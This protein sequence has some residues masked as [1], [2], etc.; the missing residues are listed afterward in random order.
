MAALAVFAVVFVALTAVQSR[1]VRLAEPADL[2]TALP[3]ALPASATATATVEGPSGRFAIGLPDDVVRVDD[4][5]CRGSP[6]PVL[7]RPSTGEVY[8]FERWPD[9]GEELPARL[10]ARVAGAHSLETLPRTA[11]A[12]CP[13]LLAVTDTTSVPITIEASP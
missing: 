10:V 7:L 11:A 5:L 9:E 8:F 13:R 4:W 12:P 6:L 1:R 2:P 3:P